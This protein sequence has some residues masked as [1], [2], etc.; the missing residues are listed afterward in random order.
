MPKESVII[1]L[2]KHRSFNF[3][4]CSKKI[5]EQGKDMII[6]RSSIAKS[7]GLCPRENV[8]PAF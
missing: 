7:S 1:K 4:L 6:V 3:D 8:K 5:L 2:H